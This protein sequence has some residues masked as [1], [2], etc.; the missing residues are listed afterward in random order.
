MIN[1]EFFSWPI[2][3]SLNRLFKTLSESISS[4]GKWGD[5][6]R[7]NKGLFSSKILW[8]YNQVEKRKF[9]FPFESKVVVKYGLSAKWQ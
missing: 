1:T 2:N 4:S 8:S 3:K 5:W 9:M 6:D 7:L